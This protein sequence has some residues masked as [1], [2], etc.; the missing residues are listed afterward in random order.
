MNQLSPIAAKQA[1]SMRT[2]GLALPVADFVKYESERLAEIAV[3]QKRLMAQ[4]DA[5]D[6]ELK[7]LATQG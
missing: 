6:Q 2:H 4:H 5:L 3:E 7:D 1:W